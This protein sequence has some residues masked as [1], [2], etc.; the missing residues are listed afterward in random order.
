M[1]LLGEI[2]LPEAKCG[3]AVR[4]LRRAGVE[5]LEQDGR[6]LNN[7]AFQPAGGTR[8]RY[9]V[10]L[11]VIG[12]GRIAEAF[13]GRFDA[14]SFTTTTEER[15]LHEFRSRLLASMSREYLPVYRIADGEFRFLLGRRVRWEREHGL[16]D[17]L[18]VAA[19]RLGLIHRRGRTSWGEGYERKLRRVLKEKLTDDI[20]TIAKHGYLAVLLSDNGCRLAHEYRHPFCDHAAATGIPF[21]K[22]SYVPFHFVCELLSGPG[23]EE[24]LQKRR[25][26]IATGFEGKKMQAIRKNMTDLGAKDVQLLGISADRSML[27]TIQASAVRQPVDLCLV[28]AGV[29]AA[30]ILV[31]LQGLNTVVLDIGGHLHCFEDSSFVSHAVFRSPLIYQP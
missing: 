4:F 8:P 3:Q 26:L 5:R 9:R 12:G 2:R 17:C 20:R 11:K 30:N 1:V 13:G 27:D 24:F 7:V 18:A 21:G 15:W 19:E 28:A 16:R 14:W 6:V 23:W 29:G 10:P 25:I 22:D 31:Q